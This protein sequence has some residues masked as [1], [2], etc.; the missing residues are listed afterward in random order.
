MLHIGRFR[1]PAACRVS[2]R[3]SG[4]E[5]RTPSPRGQLTVSKAEAAQMLGLSVDMF[6]LHVGPEIRVVRVGRRVLV[7][8]VELERWVER[9]AV[10]IAG[11]RS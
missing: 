8:V 11:A 10:R 5:G 6:E 9:R 1:N 7:P 3:V 2:E 4:G